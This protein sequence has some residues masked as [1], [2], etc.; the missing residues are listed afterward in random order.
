MQYVLKN[1]SCKPTPSK[2]A[3]HRLPYLKYTSVIAQ[4]HKRNVITNLQLHPCF[5][6]SRP[7]AARAW[8]LSGSKLGSGC[9]A[10]PGWRKNFRRML[11]GEQKITLSLLQLPIMY[12]LRSEKSSLRRHF[13]QLLYKT[14][15]LI[16]LC[17]IYGIL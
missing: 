10:H 6:F 9:V 4:N 2:E 13:L 11:S 15:L 17:S 7:S 12:F 16:F 8:G 1:I 3:W 5:L 14:S